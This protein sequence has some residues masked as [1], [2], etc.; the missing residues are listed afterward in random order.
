MALLAASSK[1]LE[2]ERRESERL[3]DALLLLESK[4]QV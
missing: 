3:L 2:A 1:D 4:Q